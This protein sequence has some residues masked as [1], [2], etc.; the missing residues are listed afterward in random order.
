MTS[1]QDGALNAATYGIGKY[2][3]NMGNCFA[4]EILSNNCVRIKDGY[5]LNQGR[6]M[7]M[8]NGDY[9][10]IVIDNGTKGMKRADLIVMRYSVNSD[11][12]IETAEMIVIKGV[13]GADYVDPDIVTGDIL[14]GAVKDDFLLYRVKID[15]INLV[16][17]EPLFD[18]SEATTKITSDI[19]KDLLSLEKP[20]Y[21][22]PEEP[23]ELASGEKLGSA[24]GKLAATVK[25]FLNF[26]RT[27]KDDLLSAIY[28]VGSIYMSTNNVD[29]QALFGGKWEQIKDRFLLSAGD[30]YKAGATGGEATHTLSTAEMPPHGHSF[31]GTT[32]TVSTDHSHSGNTSWA[33]NHSHTGS[34]TPNDCQSGSNRHRFNAGGTTYSSSPLTNEAGNHYHNFTT[35]G[36]SQNHQHGFSGNTANTGSGVAHNNMPPYL[37]VYVWKRTA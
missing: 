20:E 26:K 7:G 21:D 4:A 3:F 8:E 30:A 16:A 19:R 6:F 28:P 5:G 31:S 1:A 9:E 13:A 11:T 27:A 37:V 33:G 17:V 22:V 25:D 32:G 36:I 14:A 34:Y 18:I 29:P 15:D 35:G 12:G 10:D 2:V 24:L 23:E